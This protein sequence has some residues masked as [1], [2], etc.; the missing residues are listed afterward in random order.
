MTFFLR[1]L[2]ALAI[3][4]TIVALA[5]G[6]AASRPMSISSAVLGSDW[7]CTHA[8][9]VITTCALKA[10]RQAASTLETGSKID[11]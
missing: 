10:Q 6:A 4:S 1:N 11:R 3:A 9:F 7:Q 5:G 8:A 2:K